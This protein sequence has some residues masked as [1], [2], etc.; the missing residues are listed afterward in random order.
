M[1]ATPS[2][3]TTPYRETTLG[4]FLADPMTRA[5]M[6]AD[7]VDVGSL[8]RMLQFL[9]GRLAPQPTAR[10]AAGAWFG[11]SILNCRQ[12]ASDEDDSSAA[13]RLPHG[14]LAAGAAKTTRGAHCGR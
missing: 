3:V 2:P 7:R 1:E 9:A 13:G 11:R 6:K 5:L 8:E 10:A 12:W 14:A 4:E